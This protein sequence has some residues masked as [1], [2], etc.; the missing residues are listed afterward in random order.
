MRGL[1]GIR[2]RR[3]TAASK[4]RESD[5]QQRSITPQAQARTSD[6]GITSRDDR[7]DLDNIQQRKVR[8]GISA[9]N[10]DNVDNDDN[11]YNDNSAEGAG[12]VEI[13]AHVVRTT[14]GASICREERSW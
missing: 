13:S 8:R 4:H 2:S 14:E 10:D 3:R 1:A 11:L 7:A 6:E 9:D 5:D 12:S